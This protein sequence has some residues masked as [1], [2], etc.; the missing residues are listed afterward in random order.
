[1][2]DVFF[3]DEDA[4]HVDAEVVGE[5]VDAMGVLE[6]VCVK[7]FVWLLIGCIDIGDWLLNSMFYW[8]GCLFRLLLPCLGC[9]FWGF[10][11]EFSISDT[12]A[13]S[14]LGIDIVATWGERFKHG[15]A[16]VGVFVEQRVDFGFGQA[17]YFA[18]FSDNGIALKC[19]IGGQERCAMVFVFVEDVSGNVVSV[20]P[21]KVKVE[22]GRTTPMWVNKSLEVEVEVY[23]VHIRNSQAVGNHGVGAGATADVE[24]VVFSGE[25]TDVPIDKEV[26]GKSE[27]VDHL[28]FLF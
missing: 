3:G 9:S 5:V 15:I 11:T 14:G 28:H 19:A 8:G 13:D 27:F 18:E 20:L 23:G 10:S 25:S 12:V 4:A 22:V 26:G 21:R 2:V 17:K 6:E 1:M 16:V 24:V 7:G